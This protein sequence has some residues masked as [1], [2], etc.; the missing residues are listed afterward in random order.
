MQL[1]RVYEYVWWGQFDLGSAL[2][3]MRKI[4]GKRIS[5]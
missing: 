4:F 1:S 3:V 2:W 5:V